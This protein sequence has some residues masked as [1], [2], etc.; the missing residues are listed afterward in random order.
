MK[1]LICFATAAL[2]LAMM[3][4]CDPKQEESF[5]TRSND[6][7]TTQGQETQDNGQTTEG[8]TT[9]EGNT[10]STSEN[11]VDDENGWTNPY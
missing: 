8:G 3:V 4:S 5:D 2:L 9:A 11:G 1:K 6:T 10:T 7:Q